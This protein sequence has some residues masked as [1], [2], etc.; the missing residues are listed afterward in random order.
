MGRHLGDLA[1]SLGF[2]FTR[3]FEGRMPI[4]GGGLINP[5]VVTVLTA[6]SPLCFPGLIEL[7]WIS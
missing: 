7:P 4:I 5:V 3:R 6:R 2:G 1:R